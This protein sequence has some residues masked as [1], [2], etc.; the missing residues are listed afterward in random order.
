MRPFNS[1]T[2]KYSCIFKGIH[3]GISRKFSSQ[4]DEDSRKNFSFSLASEPVR[5]AT[6]HKPSTRGT[7]LAAC[8][9][10]LVDRSLQY[11]APSVMASGPSF[12]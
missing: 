9:L 2:A 5:Q 4:A 8:V 3:F 10:R 12:A 11:T 1:G 6:C 7:N